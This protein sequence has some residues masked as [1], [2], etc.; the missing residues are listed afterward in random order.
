MT[1]E[2]APETGA[3]NFTFD[4]DATCGTSDGDLVKRVDANG[5][6][7]CYGYDA[8]HRVTE[9]S[10]PTL[11]SGVAAT[12]NK[13]FVYDAASVDSTTMANVAGKLAEAYTA[14]P[15]TPATH[16]TDLGFSYPNPSSDQE[17][18][19]QASPSSGG[20]Y[21]TT[22]Q[23]YPNGSPSTLTLPAG[24][25][26]ITY[27]LDGEGRLAS[28]AASSQPLAA[29]S[30]GAAYAPASLT[31]VAFGSS[32][33]GGT[34]AYTYDAATGR[35]TQYQFTVGGQTDTGALTWNDNGSLASLAISDTITGTSDSQTCAFTHDD[36]GRIA[37]ANCGSGWDQTFDFDPFGNLSKSA[38]A[39]T[40]FSA[41]FNLKNEISSVGSVNGVY[42]SDGNLLNN[43]S[44]SNTQ[45][46]WF[47]AGGHATTLNNTT[48]VY[49][50]LG[51]AA[52]FTNGSTTN[53]YLYGPGGAKLAVMTG[54][55]LEYA[56][57]PL[58]GGGDAE[59][60][61]TSGLIAYHHAERSA[62]SGRP[63]SRAGASKAGRAPHTSPALV[64][65]PRQARGDP[66][67]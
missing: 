44:S 10:Y 29:A 25:P 28:A 19:Y 5:T 8:L 56:L 6:V 37:T 15:S 11:G 14:N 38:T 51:R 9:V 24:V 36:L 32:G 67:P 13:Y 17:D 66:R 62:G 7:T 33:A 4:T 63:G 1:A 55:S 59:Y 43:P 27:G 35:M 61:Q 22:L 64:A 12:P 52:E 54:Q 46:N 48:V 16:I 45:V 42:D 57:I 26:A 60:Y 23:H 3:T 53:E 50:A 39:G 47:D 30:Y 65:S 58:P 49:D 40:Q 18:V 21:V 2:T 31:Q 34:D 41:S 20:W